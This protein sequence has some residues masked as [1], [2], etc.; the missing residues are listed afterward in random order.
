MWDSYVSLCQDWGI[1]I[2][3]QGDLENDEDNDKLN[4]VYGDTQE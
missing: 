2:S 4:I 3:E 1:G